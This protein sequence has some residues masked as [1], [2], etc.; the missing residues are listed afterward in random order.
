MQ[1]GFF[2]GREELRTSSSWEYAQAAG[3][4]NIKDTRSC[5]DRA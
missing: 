1:D 5:D 3:F 4:E 2:A